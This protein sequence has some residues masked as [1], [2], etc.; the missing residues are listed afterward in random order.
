MSYAP[1]YLFQNMKFKFPASFLVYK[2]VL[3]TF[4]LFI[5]GSPQYWVRTTVH[6]WFWTI[7]HISMV[8]KIL[9]GCQKMFWLLSRGHSSIVPYI[10]N[11]CNGFDS[12]KKPNEDEKKCF[13]SWNWAIVDDEKHMCT[14]QI[15]QNQMRLMRKCFFPELVWWWSWISSCFSK[16]N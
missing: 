9:Q 2:F 16:I 10:I 15:I 12:S 11:N 7:K 8:A 14:H 6:E 13:N 5:E 4:D 1:L 3:F